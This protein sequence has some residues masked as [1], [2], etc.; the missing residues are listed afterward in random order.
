MA[1]WR[2]RDLEDIVGAL[3]DSGGFTEA[4]ILRLVQQIPAESEFVDYKSRGEFKKPRGSKPWSVE[5]EHAKDVCGSANGRGG[6]LIYGVEDLVKV[7]VAADRMQP[8]DA[9][10][11][12]HA[13]MEQLRQD[14]RAYSAPTPVFEVFAVDSDLKADCFYL[15][16]VTPA[17]PNAPHAVTVPSGESRKALHYYLRVPGETSHRY[18]L[19]HEV[20]ERYQGRIRTRTQ[21]EQRLE[22]VWAHAQQELLDQGSHLWVV[23]AVIPD[24]PADDFLGALARKEIVEWNL[25]QR[26][27]NSILQPNNVVGDYPFPAPGAMVF[28]NL[29][30]P[31]EDLVPA[32]KSTY[33]EIHADGTALAAVRVSPENLE[34]GPVVLDPDFLVDDLCSMTLHVLSWACERSGGRGTA[35]VRAALVSRTG[36][37]VKLAGAAGTQVHGLRQLDHRTMPVTTTSTDL[38]ELVDTQSILRVASVVVTRIVQGFGMPEPPWLTEDGEIDMHQLPRVALGYTRDW[39]KVHNVSS[40]GR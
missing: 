9:S 4:A 1:I 39:L 30:R 10:S 16:V 2:H 3:L 32:A 25:G 27:P 35:T 21:R 8:F 11:D 37:S 29:D 7:D 22:E 14:V 40:S 38:A 13:I 15:V 28:T 5:Q 18:L 31:G 20:F 6:L 17:S 24:M 19:E 12:Q 23:V 36:S 26:F 33:R 34:S